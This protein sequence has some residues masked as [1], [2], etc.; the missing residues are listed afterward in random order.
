MQQR[1]RKRATAPKRSVDLDLAPFNGRTTMDGAA[2]RAKHSAGLFMSRKMKNATQTV[3]YRRRWEITESDHVLV[4]LPLFNT[5]SLEPLVTSLATSKWS[6]WTLCVCK[7]LVTSAAQTRP[8][9]ESRFSNQGHRQ[10]EKSSW[11]MQISE[12]FTDSDQPSL[13]L[14]PKISLYTRTMVENSAFVIYCIKNHLICWTVNRNFLLHMNSSAQ[15][16]PGRFSE[17]IQLIIPLLT[18]L[19]FFF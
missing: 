11:L 2:S 10:Q 18:I 13:K 19:F 1:K 3:A 15:V 6:Y 12:V 17:I 14:S 7:S 16:K 8:L 5:M 4:F 9:G